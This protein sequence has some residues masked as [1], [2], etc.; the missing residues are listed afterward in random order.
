[1]ETPTHPRRIDFRSEPEY[2][3]ACLEHLDR[4]WVG[5]HDIYERALAFK[6]IDAST[7]PLQRCCARMVELICI[8]L[9]GGE[10]SPAE[11]SEWNHLVAARRALRFR[12]QYL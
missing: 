9:D 5:R 10:W 1:M 3:I 7:T 12:A 4:E 6:R 2:L 11:E 8:E